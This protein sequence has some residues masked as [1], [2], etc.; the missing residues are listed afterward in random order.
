VDEWETTNLNRTSQIAGGS[1]T[2]AMPTSSG[3]SYTAATNQSASYSY[4]AAGDVTYD[5]LNSY[6]YDAERRLCAVRNSN[7]SITAYVY[8]AAGTRVA[9]GSLTSFTCNFATNGFAANTSW[10]GG[11]GLTK[12]SGYSGSRL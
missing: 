8:D 5:G 10:A 4:D 2:V 3:V 9:K 7:N 11:A 6:L 1:P 12:K